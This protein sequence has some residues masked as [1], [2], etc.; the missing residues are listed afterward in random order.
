MNIDI[1]KEQYDDLLRAVYMADWMANAIC[2]EDAEKDRGIKDIRNHIFSF[3]KE[4]GLEK[5]VEYDPEYREWYAALALDDD[6]RVRDLIH[7][8]EDH[9]FWEEAVDRFGER[10]FFERYSDEERAKMGQKDRMR[11]V[12]E[13]EE[14]WGN[15]FEKYGLDRL[16]VVEERG[17]EKESGPY[18]SLSRT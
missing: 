3:A 4:A 6:E 1:S 17:I 11:K 5:F 9:V 15:E 16:R 13:C 7:R 18:S 12:W 8:Y 2:S 10:D 14:T